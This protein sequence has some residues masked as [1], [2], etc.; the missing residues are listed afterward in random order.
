M[1]KDEILAVA[2]RV[3][4]VFLVLNVLGYGVS[5]TLS[6][7][8]GSADG[9]WFPSAAWNLLLLLVAFL[10]WRRAL[11]VARKILPAHPSPADTERGQAKWTFR[12]VQEVVLPILGI[13]ALIQAAPQLG[14]WITFSIRTDPEGF[15]ESE[16]LFGDHVS[17]LVSIS[18]ELLF[19]LWLLL[20]SKGIANFLHRLRWAG[21]PEEPSSS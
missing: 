9:P 13:Q 8:A 10:L 4:A 1:K 2:L 7:A 12:S 15:S 3:A 18:V 19:G 20:G 17:R 11:P 6:A 16:W 14:Y 5:S 21:L